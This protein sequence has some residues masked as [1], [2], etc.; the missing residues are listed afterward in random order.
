[1]L[2][3]KLKIN[4]LENSVKKMEARGIEPGRI[5]FYG[6]SAFTRWSEQYGMPVLEDEIRMKDG[7]KAV[8]NHGFGGSTAEEQLYYYDRLIKAFSPRALVLLTFGN[9]ND[10]NY[11][12]EEILFLQSRLIA[13]ARADFPDL[14]VFICNHRP[15]ALYNNAL[16]GIRA[17][18]YE[19][20][21]L[22][23][24]YLSHHPE[25]TLIDLFH[26]E[27]FYTSMEEAGNIKATREDLF[28]EDRVHFNEEGYAIFKD[29]FLKALDS[30]L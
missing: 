7:S 2:E 11:S 25:V 27:R 21:E 5:I 8:L 14:K 28:I 17:A 30:L 3:P 15:F 24:I 20:N 6:D 19:Y 12:P 13:Y 18:V 23:N 29:I 22:L 1:M 16:P 9:D 26:D 4:R 10:V